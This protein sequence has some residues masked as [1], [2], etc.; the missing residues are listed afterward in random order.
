M[1]GEITELFMQLDTRLDD[2]M[3]EYPDA[4]LWPDLNSIWAKQISKNAQ[5]FDCDGISEEVI[6]AGSY[7]AEMYPEPDVPPSIDV[8]LPNKVTILGFSVYKLAKNRGI[9]MTKEGK[10]DQ[11]IVQNLD[12]SV[13]W[14]T[15]Y[16]NRYYVCVQVG[17]DASHFEVFSIGKEHSPTRVGFIGG[18]QHWSLDMRLYERFK[19][20]EEFISACAGS[21]RRV[22]C[23]LQ[24]INTPRFVTVDK[25]GTR[26]ARRSAHRGGG[27]A[28][29]AWHKVSWDVDAPVKAKS[30]YDTGFHKLPL[31]FRRGHWRKAKQSDPKSVLRR[32]HWKT[33]VEGYYA[34]HPAF[35]FKKTYHTPKKVA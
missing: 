15:A 10:E 34:G 30:P 31:H 9:A 6:G 33:W 14:G 19:D 16:T 32:G 22:A 17:D 12:N 28:M 8:R 26:Q 11:R 7:E 5:I 3:K 25:E 2:Y 4:H 1:I 35:G 24:T 23:L 18:S 20:Q 21:L 13:A 27:F 29:D